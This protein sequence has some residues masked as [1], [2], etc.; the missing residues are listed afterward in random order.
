MERHLQFVRRKRI[1][2]LAL[3]LE[4]PSGLALADDGETL[5]TVDDESRNVFTV[6]LASF[7]RNMLAEEAIHNLSEGFDLLT[8]VIE[9]ETETGHKELATNIGNS[10]VSRLLTNIENIQSSATE[11]EPQLEQ[12]FYL[13]A[14]VQAYDFGDKKVLSDAIVKTAGALFRQYM[15]DYTK[16]EKKAASRRT[17]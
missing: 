15:R 1:Q 7:E 3:G 12:I 9:D 10:Y 16:A 5:Y 14:E 8:D 13:L 11:T 17:R 4:E 6:S 2:T